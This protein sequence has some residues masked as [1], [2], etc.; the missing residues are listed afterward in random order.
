MSGGPSLQVQEQAT[1]W[2]Q[3]GRGSS[4][5]KALRRV[6]V[7]STSGVMASY[8][9]VSDALQ[10][11]HLGQEEGKSSNSRRAHRKV[12]GLSTSGVMASQGNV[13]DALH[14]TFRQGQED[15]RSSGCKL[16]HIRVQGF[17]A[18]FNR[19]QALWRVQGAMALPNPVRDTVHGRRQG[20]EGLPCPLSQPGQQ[21]RL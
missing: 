20:Q 7:S 4:C 5:K 10:C 3:Q 6:Q 15:V 8:G 19:E 11:K 2:Q 9:S 21:Q 13:R 12:Q 16:A 17:S 18:L 14:G 1:A